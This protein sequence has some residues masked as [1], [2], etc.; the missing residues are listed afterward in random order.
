MSSR[1]LHAGADLSLFRGVLVLVL[2]QI[3][4]SIVR[5]FDCSIGTAPLKVNDSQGSR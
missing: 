4:C 5:L 1:A 2:V 3:D